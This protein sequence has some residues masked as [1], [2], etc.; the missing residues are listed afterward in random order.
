MVGKCPTRMCLQRSEWQ[1]GNKELAL[2]NE[3]PEDDRERHPGYQARTIT[4]EELQ[5]QSLRDRGW[6][7]ALPLPAV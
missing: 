2:L 3:D 6:N 5:P 1:M 7:P 4:A